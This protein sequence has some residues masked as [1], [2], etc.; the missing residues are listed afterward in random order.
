LKFDAKISE[1]MKASM[2]VIETTRE[3]QI[4]ERRID[5]NFYQDQYK[6]YMQIYILYTIYIIPIHII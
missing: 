6:I 5:I 1:T 3:N 2:A 4:I